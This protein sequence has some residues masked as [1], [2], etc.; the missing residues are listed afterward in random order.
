MFYPLQQRKPAFLLASRLVIKAT[1]CTIQYVS[2]KNNDNGQFDM[3]SAKAEFFVA[4]YETQKKSIARNA[5]ALS[6]LFSKV[7]ERSTNLIHVRFEIA[8]LTYLTEESCDCHHHTSEFRSCLLTACLPTDSRFQKSSS[9]RVSV[10]LTYMCLGGIM[11][12]IQCKSTIFTE[13]L[14]LV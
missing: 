7:L 11:H 2:T 4:R 14:K 9:I 10:T 5:Q 6:A 1:C 13:M 12:G 3:V 8:C